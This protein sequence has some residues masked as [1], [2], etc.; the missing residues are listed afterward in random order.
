MMDSFR[1][2]L[3]RRIFDAKT[4]LV[5]GRDRAALTEMLAVERL[6]PQALAA[7]VAE[8]SARI[9]LHAFR[10][11]EF[12]REHYRSAGFTEADVAE[13][14][15]FTSLP[16]LTKQHLQ[17]A[18][19]ALV[20]ATSRP[21]DR[22][23]SRTGGSTGR[24][25]IVQNDRTAPTAALWWRVHSWWGIH[26][27]DDVAYIYRQSRRGRAKLAH[28]LEWWPTRQVLLD[29]RGTTADSMEEFA[30]AVD[31]VRPRLLTG[32]VEGVADYAR[33][34]SSGIGP[35]AGLRAISVTASSLH[36]G[37]RTVIEQALGAPVHDTYRSA[38][39]SWIAAE[40]SG[41]R[42]L[43]VLADRR[44]V[45]V[46]DADG[47]TVPDGQ[48]GEVLV[49]DFDNRVFPLVRYRIGDRT[50]VLSGPCPC[51]RTLGRID[52]L[53]GRVAD[54]LRAPSGRTVSGGLGGLF[55]PWPGAVRQFQ[56]HQGRDHRISIRYVAGPD[57]AA[58]AEAAEQVRRQVAGFLA[59]EVA[60][61]AVPVSAVDSSGGKA[62]LVVSEVTT[63]GG[64]PEGEETFLPGGAPRV[65]T[66][67]SA[68]R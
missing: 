8:R 10:T 24:P 40:C 38:E 39:V 60:V 13:P 37:Q 9:A 46:V 52:H 42:G 57:P 32:Y 26:P 16:A 55:N 65:Y 62:R 20:S 28:T 6:A 47:V 21:R 22:L 61:E 50:R 64:V 35:P 23:P 17:D 43:H 34:V 54:I 29:A 56:V 12:Y 33:H 49:T 5:M 63:K 58:A 36:A 53:D 11:T 4:R 19:D 59:G 44:R 66:Q 48:T 51:G 31:R 27:G 67:G 18:P 41:H 1:P 68:D 15:N 14:S 30:R 25:L 7:L 2:R 45:E 3:Q